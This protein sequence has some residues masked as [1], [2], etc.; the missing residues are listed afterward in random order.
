MNDE[1]R[2]SELIRELAALL[3][4]YLRAFNADREIGDPE[5]D[6]ITHCA[7]LAEFLAKRINDKF[8][9]QVIVE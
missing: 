3:T 1:N 8:L 9:V 7:S 5:F 4:P 6:D 2:K